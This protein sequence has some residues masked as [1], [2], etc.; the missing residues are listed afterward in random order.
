MLCHSLAPRNATRTLSHRHTSHTPFLPR[1]PEC[2]NCRPKYGAKAGDETTTHCHSCTS[3]FQD[4]VTTNLQKSA[5]ELADLVK[6]ANAY[7]CILLHAE[8]AANWHYSCLTTPTQDPFKRHDTNDQEDQGGSGCFSVATNMVHCQSTYAMTVIV[9]SLHPKVSLVCLLSN[10]LV[11]VLIFR[12]THQI[13]Q[14]YQA[15]ASRDAIRHIHL[16]RKRV[17]L[18]IFPA[19]TNNDHQ[20]DHMFSRV[21]I[22]IPTTPTSHF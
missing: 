13:T 14:T 19:L 18:G 12:F 15:V 22:H 5:F 16:W 21:S 11:W 9:S 2:N 4:F 3:S 7:K 8:F 10:W 6:S 20:D 1:H 17:C